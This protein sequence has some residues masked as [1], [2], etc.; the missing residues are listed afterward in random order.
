MNP[1]KIGGSISYREM[2]GNTSQINNYGSD[3]SSKLNKSIR[4][5]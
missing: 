1:S 3:A 5:P 4:K 2:T